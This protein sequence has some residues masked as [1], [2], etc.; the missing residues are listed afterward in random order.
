MR[1]THL[2]DGGRVQQHVDG[3][4]VRFDRLLATERAPWGPFEF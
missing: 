1:T 2:L 4:A 3:A